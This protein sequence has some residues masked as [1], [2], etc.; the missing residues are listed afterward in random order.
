MKGT[1][2]GYGE[3]RNKKRPL[4]TASFITLSLRLLFRHGLLRFLT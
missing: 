1:G 3:H 4:S 2:V